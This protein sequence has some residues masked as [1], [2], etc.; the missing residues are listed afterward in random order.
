MALY[1]L[2]RTGRTAVG[3]NTD[4][5]VHKGFPHLRK[6]GSE[7]LKRHPERCRRACFPVLSRYG[8]C[9]YMDGKKSTPTSIGQTVAGVTRAKC[10]G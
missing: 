1:C 2:P 3:D 10:F 5:N 6:F 4:T 7:V 8:C 9:R